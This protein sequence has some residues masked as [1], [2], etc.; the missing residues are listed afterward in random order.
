MTDEPSRDEV[1][2][3]WDALA[4]YWDD[5][6]EAGNTWQRNLIQPA[7]ERL[8][9]LQSGEHVL[10]IACGNGEFSRRMASLGARVLATDFSE[11]M[12]DRARARGGEV[13]YRRV[14]ATDQEALRALGS[15]GPFD[16][17][18][19]NMAI[20]DM[21]EI[22]PMAAATATLLRPGG[23]FVVSTTH[24]AFNGGGATRVVEQ[25]EDETGIVRRYFVKVSSYITTRIGKGVAIE[26]QPVTQWYFD[27]P[28]SEIFS[29][30]FRHGWILDG[31]EEPVLSRDETSEDGTSRIY[32]EIPGVL[33]ARFRR[34]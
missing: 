17:A 25:T 27:R 31:M 24:P 32:T 18:V 22:E 28:I 2:G 23:R 12:L 21:R 11:G 1:R 8:L 15:D 16:A 33:V 20:M 29:T 7:V 13:E 3:S 14:D 10:E 19:C 34:P 26:G 6:M 4:P 9:E 5:Q 30:F